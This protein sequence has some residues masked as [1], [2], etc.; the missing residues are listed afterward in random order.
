MQPFPYLGTLCYASVF[1][2][3]SAAVVRGPRL[4]RGMRVPSLPHRTFLPASLIF[5]QIRI[6]L[7]QRSLGRARQ[8]KNLSKTPLS[9]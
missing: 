2:M 8:D 6:A 3:F 9:N 4:Q 1:R 7:L 5:S